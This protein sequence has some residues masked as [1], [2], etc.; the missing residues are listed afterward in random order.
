MTEKEMKAAFAVAL[1]KDLSNPFK[2]AMSVIGDDDPGNT[3]DAAYMAAKWPKDPEVI[4]GMRRLESK[5][6]EL[7]FLPT[8]ADL[9]R[10]IWDM[11][12]K[13][14]DASDAVKLLK[15]YGEVMGYIEK[16]GTNVNV[17]AR[18]LSRN[19]MIVK[20]HDKDSW[21]AKAR[22]QQKGLTS[23]GESSIH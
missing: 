11:V 23:D 16:P 9:G 17:D 7:A 4:E 15:L 21:E 22:A 12:N 18:N 14:L 20:S 13:P 8:K 19:V 5:E 3:A 10:K 1:L 2:A 6:G